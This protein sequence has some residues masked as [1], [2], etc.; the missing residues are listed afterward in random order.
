MLGERLAAREAEV[1]PAAPPGRP[2]L[3]LLALDPSSARP[4][5]APARLG[6][7]LVDA[8]LEP[9]R[10][11]RRSA[12]SRRARRRVARLQ[13]GDRRRPRARAP[14]RAPARGRC[15]SAACR[16]GPG[17]ARRAVVVRLTVARQQHG[18]GPGEKDRARPVRPWKSSSVS[19]RSPRRSVS[20]EMHVR[21]QHVAEVDL[22]ARSGWMNQTCWCFCGASK[23]SRSTSTSW[24]IS[25]IRPVRASP[26]GRYMPASPV[27][28]PSQ[29]TCSAPASS[30]LADQL[31]PAVRREQRRAGP[32][33][34]PRRTP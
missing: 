12:R 29:T 18:S 23:I 21:G 11:R 20:S 7:P 27:A 28:R 34:R 8:R 32:S 30:A 6:E 10:G 31:D 26:S 2:Q 17:R 24:T 15:R 4:S 3:G 22:A 14:A 1:R 19:A 25:S 13:R 16:A 5:H 33:P 9:E